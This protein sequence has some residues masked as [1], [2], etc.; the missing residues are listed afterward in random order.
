MANMSDKE[1]AKQFAAHL[2]V[3]EHVRSNQTIGIGSGSTIVYAV[4]KI[5]ELFNTNKLL[6]IVCVPTS[7]QSEQLILAKQLPLGNLKQNWQIDVAID[8]ADEVDANLNCIKGGGGCHLQEKMVAFNAKKFIVIA[9]DSKHSKNLCHNYRKGVPLSFMA[10]SIAYVKHFI[11]KNLKAEIQ[12]LR[13]RNI[14]CVLR[15]AQN[16]AGPVIT[17]DG[18]MIYDIQFDGVLNCDEVADINKVLRMI[19]GVVETGLF[20]NMAEMAYFG[21]MNGSVIKQTKD[22]TV[23]IKPKA[24]DTEK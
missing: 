4:D 13:N 8:G 23:V 20:V 16:K 12:S 19:P 2:A 15:M 3:E 7:F 9:D 17:D 6:N 5:A 14:E 11:A 24:N 22:A 18:H 10:D 1:K 21:Q